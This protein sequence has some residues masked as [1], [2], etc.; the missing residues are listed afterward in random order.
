MP[1][2]GITNFA[3][4]KCRETRERFQF[5]RHFCGIV[6]SGEVGIVKPAPAIFRRLA[7]DH[8]VDLSRCVF[9]DDVVKDVAGAEP[10][11]LQAI[12]FTNPADLRQ[13]WLALGVEGV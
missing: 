12:H 4:D 9:I 6:V 10:V 7:T 2:Y 8:G 13:R 1:L 11:S 3:A 5:F